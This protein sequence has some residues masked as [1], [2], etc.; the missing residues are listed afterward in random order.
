[1]RDIYCLCT[2]RVV[3][4]IF[5]SVRII[6]ALPAMFVYECLFSQKRGAVGRTRD[7]A[8]HPHLLSYLRILQQYLQ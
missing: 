7:A 3:T 2:A 8:F 6:R 4:R 5:P 1:M